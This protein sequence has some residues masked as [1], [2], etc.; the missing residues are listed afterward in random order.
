MK[1][2]KKI[3]AKTQKANKQTP[4]RTAAQKTPRVGATEAPKNIETLARDIRTRLEDAD[5]EAT[6]NNYE[7]GQM[8]NEAADNPA[9]FG[10]APDAPVVQLVA[11][12]VGYQQDTIYN[13]ARVARAWARKDFTQW[14]TRKGKNGSVL[15]FAHFVEVVKLKDP[16][17]RD[18]MLEQALTEGLS[19]RQL[20]QLCKKPVGDRST[21][22]RRISGKRML[23]SIIKLSEKCEILFGQ[24]PDA[25]ASFDGKGVTDPAWLVDR[26]QEVQHHVKRLCDENAKLLAAKFET[27]TRTADR[28]EEEHMT[29]GGDGE[30]RHPAADR[31]RQE[32]HLSD[33]GEE[34]HRAA[35]VRLPILSPSKVEPVPSAAGGAA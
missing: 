19:T 27:L 3:K 33:G 15:S 26:A 22:G 21:S 8:V 10:L 14:R 11:E 24:L 30:Q 9:A 12:K 34:E 23:Q 13:G 4:R 18:E 6:L 7:V 5:K 2:N 32:E 29:D 16:G 31:E 28:K 17:K 25:L 20:R 35:V 1:A